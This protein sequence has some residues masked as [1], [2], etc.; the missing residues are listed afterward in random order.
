MNHRLQN[1]NQLGAL[2]CLV[3]ERPE[4]VV[5]RQL[6]GIER[7]RVKRWR[8][9]NL[10]DYFSRSFQSQRDRSVIVDLR[11]ERISSRRPVIVQVFTVELLDRRRLGNTV[12]VLNDENQSSDTSGMLMLRGQ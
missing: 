3:I 1:V 9:S 2:D 10:S 7:P 11:L 6:R 12:L 4:P 8:L 5:G